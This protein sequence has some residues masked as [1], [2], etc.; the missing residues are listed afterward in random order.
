MEELQIDWNQER[1]TDS[2]VTQLWKEIRISQLTNFS[3]GF[4]QLRKSINETH[5]NGGIQFH[6][7]HLTGN[8]HFNWFASRNRLDEINFINKILNRPELEV[9]RKNLQI[10]SKPKFKRIGWSTDIFELPSILARKL[11]QG[12][13]YKK[14]D[15]VTSWEIATDFVKQE[16]ENRFDEFEMFNIAIENAE[17]FYDIAWD[18][19]AMIYDKRKTELNIIDITDTD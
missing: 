6:K 14:L 16:F 5:V 13:A 9:Y 19:T 8:K 17:W 1:P 4:E 12:G 11:N 3:D 2:E 15:S 7:F 18:W 10:N